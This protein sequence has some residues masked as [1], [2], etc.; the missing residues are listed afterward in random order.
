[1]PGFR[2]SGGAVII[3][4][5]RGSVLVIVA[6]WMS[7]AVALV[8]FVIDAGHWFEH[9]RHLQL[10][11]DAGAFAGGTAFIRCFGASAADRASSTSPANSEIETQARKF[12]GDTKNYTGALNPQVNNRPNVTVVLNSTKYPG[13]GGVDFDDPAG[14]PCQSAYIDVKSTD[15]NVPWFLADAVVPKIK[16][17]ARV[18]IQQIS[19]L[20]GSLPLAVQDVNPLAAGA[21]FVNEDATN[22]KTTISAVLGRQALVGGA[23]SV[24]NGQSLTSWTGGP[25][26]VSISSPN[27]ITNLAPAH[28]GV[29]IALCSNPAICG[30]GMGN[31]WLSGTVSGVCGQVFVTCH[32]GDQTGLEL[33]HGYTTLGVGTAA[34]PIL[35]SVTLTKGGTGACTDDSAPYFLLNAG[36]KIGVNAELDFGVTGSPASL[37]NASVK[38]GTCTLGYTGSTGTTSS[39][40]AAN[41]LTVASG[42]GQVPLA[43]DWSTGSGGSKVSGS[44]TKVARPFANDGPSATQSYPIAYAQ[45][46]RGSLC[47]DGIGYSVAFGTTEFCV[48]IGVYGSLKVAGDTTDPTVLLKFIDGSHSG[49]INCGGTN[50]N[51]DIVN[52]CTR[53]VGRNPGQACPNATMPA[54]CVPL[55]TG[56]KVG[57]V[58]QG[59]HDRFAPGDVCPVNNWSLYPNL[60]SGDPRAVPLIVTLSGAFAG[61]GGGYVPVTDFAAFYITGWDG[62]PNSGSC[63]A[64]NEAPPAGGGNGTIWG[65]FITYVGGIGSSTGGAPCNF[66]AR[67]LSPC[68]PVLTD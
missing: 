26:S 53:A 61:S 29:V 28:V 30:D 47:T 56:H 21:L 54:N 40:S 51:D 17:H 32:K 42:A 23:A 9:K 1:V 14:P 27:A 24:L 36:C 34:A 31:A 60:P 25:V 16:A 10:Q 66:A 22:F 57:Q 5:E 39:W 35:R 6:L 44:F 37:L 62:A 63:N 12:S 49:A 68:I 4:G 41:C 43:L 18:S 46:T 50:L 11:V 65:H 3:A 58:R 33:I 20:S 38:V 67:A 48:G 45:L 19:A 15:A 7:S 13:E 8:T 64:N 59:M 55:R 52:G 2:M